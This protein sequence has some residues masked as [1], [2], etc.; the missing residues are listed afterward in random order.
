[1]YILIGIRKGEQSWTGNGW[2]PDEETPVAIFEDKHEAIRYIKQNKLKRQNYSKHEI[3]RKDSVL[4][5]YDYA[6]IEHDVPFFGVK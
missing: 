1:M 2:Y 4:S 5:G 3:F 6:A